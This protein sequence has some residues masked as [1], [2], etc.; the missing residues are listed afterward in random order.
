MTTSLDFSTTVPGSEE[1]L[2]LDHLGQDC[3]RATSASFSPINHEHPL[4]YPR[5]DE[6]SLRTGAPKPCWPN[7]ASFAVC[8]THDVDQVASSN[9]RIYW[10]RIVNQTRGLRWTRNGRAVRALEASLFSFARALNPVRGPDPLHA[11]E[12]WLAME[13][14]VGAKSTF[15]F[16]PDRYA[17]PHYTD[18][19]YRYA[20]RIRF[21]GQK[22]SVAE[23]MR[24]IHRRGWEVGLHA[25]W[26]AYDCTEEMKRQKEQVE[27]AIDAPVE[28]VRQHNLHFDVRC[29][30]R[31]Q[32]EAGLLVDSSLGFND[33][34]GFRCGTCHPWFLRELESDVTLGVLE[35]PL[36][37]QDKCLIDTLGC[38]SEDLAMEWATHIIERVREVGGVFAILW[39]PGNL[40]RQRYENVY[41]R[42]LKL[43]YEKG[44]YFGTM[45]EVR[46]HWL[47][48][49][50][51]PG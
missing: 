23:M 17:R 35:L 46:Q 20:D 2:L 27:R 48:G 18:G 21:D 11:Y 51:P 49:C 40:G 33:N 15:L 37:I 38:G 24:E 26:H 34:I 32:H 3:Y 8:L 14:E 29:T 13:A 50:K 7:G 16:L 25:S 6:A 28:S 31:V 19:G 30:P 12:Q 44:A 1:A 41:R 42:V 5:V 39:H 36:I 4:Y 10:R 47:R 45:R 9:S 22:C 43:T